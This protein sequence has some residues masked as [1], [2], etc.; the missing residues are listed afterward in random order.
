MRILVITPNFTYAG[1]P[2]AQLRLA[3]ILASRGHDVELIIG[4]VP[5]N[6][7]LPSVENIKIQIWK[8]K[9]VKSMLFKLITYIKSSKP[10]VIFSAEDHLNVTVLMA[11]VLAFSSVKI[12]CSSRVTPFDTYPNKLISKGTILK[13]LQRIF[14]W[15]AESL[16][17]VSKDMVFQ[18]QKIFKNSRHVCTYNI[19][20]RESYKDQFLRMQTPE[21]FKKFSG[22]KVIIGSG[23]LAHYKG[24]DLL[25]KA[26]RKLLEK[27]E[28][29]LLIL[30]NGPD[31]I[32]LQN[33]I[34]ELQLDGKAILVGEVK[35][36]I[37]YYINADI[38][39]LSSFV[40]GMPNVLIEAMLCGCTPV[41][42]D[43]PT[44]PREILSKE[45]IGYLVPPGDI[46][47][48][49]ESLYNAIKNPASQND[50][51]KCIKPFRSDAV[52]AQHSANL[53]EQF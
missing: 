40:E 8:K 52:I 28:A 29:Y 21:I 47:L 2:L 14:M 30:G 19:I 37:N 13:L 42:F 31:Y 11:A 15:R 48:L 22:K 39:A 49:S 33:L 3:K 4:W 1:V 41:A 24:F 34:T 45:N 23:R 46:N 26:F 16:N 12:S 27:E 36:P 43:C 7:D 50:L 20:D 51:E 32:K 17:C 53:N 18:Y 25:I 44:G 35:D 5:D 10:K 6:I 9:H 38:F